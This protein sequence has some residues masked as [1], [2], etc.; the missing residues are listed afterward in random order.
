ME[1]YFRCLQTTLDTE[2]GEVLKCV[3]EYVGQYLLSLEQL[4]STTSSEIDPRDPQPFED[5]LTL[6]SLNLVRSFWK[7]DRHETLWENYFAREGHNYA[8]VTQAITDNKV[9]LQYPICTLKNSSSPPVEKFVLTSLDFPILLNLAILHYGLDKGPNCSQLRILLGKTY[10]FCGAVAA[11]IEQFMVLDL[12]HTQIESL[13]YLFVGRALRSGVLSDAERVV[14]WA[15]G[16]YCGHV[17]EVT[18]LFAL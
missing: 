15:K 5:F 9:T 14:S 17:K 8:S 12:K 11:G 10:M 1:H 16:F 6:A 7:R 3:N 18:D 13:G 2:T 4:V